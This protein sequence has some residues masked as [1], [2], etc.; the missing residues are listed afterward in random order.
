LD[1]NAAYRNR[2]P[3]AYRLWLKSYWAANPERMRQ[4]QQVRR[5]RK[6]N[7]TVERF[8]DTEIFE[9]DGYVCYICTRLTDPSSPP[10]TPLR[11]V[12]EH[13]IPLKR[14][15]DHSRANCATACWEC[16]SHK[17]QMTDTEFLALIAF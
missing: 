13:R 11:T 9:R 4:A 16:N 3:E 17:G 14:G 7:A 6:A 8:K 5:A 15:G 2:D 1:R 10:H 12:L